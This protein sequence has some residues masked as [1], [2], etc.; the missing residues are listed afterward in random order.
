MGEIIIA[1]YNN[2]A[3]LCVRGVQKIF[4]TSD[5][6]KRV[7]VK[8]FQVSSEKILQPRLASSRDGNITERRTLGVV[9]M[10]FYDIVKQI[11]LSPAAL[12]MLCLKTS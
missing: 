10:N 6:A 5:D 1:L 11:Q 9:T 8:S 2:V 3:L 7:R 12:L 4:S